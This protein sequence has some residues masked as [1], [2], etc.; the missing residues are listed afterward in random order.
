MEPVSAWTSNDLKTI[1]DAEEVRIAPLRPDGTLRKPVIVWIVR[2]GDNVYVRSVN[3]RNTAWFRGVQA[4]HAGQLSAD[5][6]NREVDL[7]EVS[8]KQDDI[9]AA[10]RS[11]YAKYPGIVPHIVT[12]ETRATTLS[13]VPRPS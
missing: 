11:K 5:G 4:R 7:L 12:P 10:Y 8:D 13:L 1:G 9:D 3:G 6:L 2:V